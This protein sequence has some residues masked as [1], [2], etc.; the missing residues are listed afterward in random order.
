MDSIQKI[1]LFLLLKEFTLPLR[2]LYFRLNC[3]FSIK[4]QKKAQKKNKTRQSYHKNF[5]SLCIRLKKELLESTKSNKG[6]MTRAFSDIFLNIRAKKCYKNLISTFSKSLL[7]SSNF[8]KQFPR[9]VGL[10][11][12]YISRKTLETR[13]IFVIRLS[14]K[15]IISA[16]MKPKESLKGKHFV[17]HHHSSW[18]SKESP[19]LRK[20]V[21]AIF[22]EWN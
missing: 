4:L 14:R 19:S 3:L 5:I 20:W 10:S 18:I 12:I 7:S 17:E 9:F 22:L 21:L 2:F 11:W 15:V 1:K 6:N 13:E 16:K 8:W